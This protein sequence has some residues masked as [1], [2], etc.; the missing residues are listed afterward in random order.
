MSQV[1]ECEQEH[2]AQVLH[3]IRMEPTCR[4]LT[5][6]THARVAPRCH[7]LMR[8]IRSHTVSRTRPSMFQCTKAEWL[9][10]GSRCAQWEAS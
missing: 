9:Q 5:S 3:D 1:A 6:M 10:N 7:G 2:G 4:S 8:D